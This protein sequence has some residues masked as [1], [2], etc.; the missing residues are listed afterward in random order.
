[1]RSRSTRKGLPA[2]EWTTNEILVAIEGQRCKLTG[3]AFVPTGNRNPW[4]PSPDRIDN[5]KGYSKSNVR[6]VC[7]AVNCLKNKFGTSELEILLS[8]LADRWLHKVGCHQHPDVL[9]YYSINQ[10][11]R[12]LSSRF[13]AF[14]ACG[15][16]DLK[17]KD[18]DY[19]PYRSRYWGTG[20]ETCNIK[21]YD[22][23][24]ALKDY[25]HAG[26]MARLLDDEDDD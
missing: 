14:V 7:Y 6:W 19:K 11:V 2:P 3:I 15:Y 12:E 13:E 26:D 9:E 1:M 18:D 8:K 4:L 20:K 10:L 23:A 25:F 22:L 24:C 17:L 16:H 5:S 21:P